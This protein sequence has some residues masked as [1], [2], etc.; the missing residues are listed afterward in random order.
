MRDIPIAVPE[1]HVRNRIDAVVPH[2]VTSATQAERFEEAAH[3]A[4]PR[5]STLHLS[6]QH[7][8]PLVR[9][10]VGLVELVSQPIF[11]L[12]PG[13]VTQCVHQEEATFATGPAGRL[14]K[15]TSGVAS[16]ATLLPHERRVS[17]GDRVGS[18]SQRAMKASDAAGA[19]RLGSEIENGRPI[20]PRHDRAS[21]V[22]GVTAREVGVRR[23]TAAR[24]REVM[25]QVNRV[26]LDGVPHDRS[27]LPFGVPQRSRVPGRRFHRTL[28][29]GPPLLGGSNEPHAL[30]AI[31]AEC[32][33]MPRCARSCLRAVP[34]AAGR[35]HQ[36][37]GAGGSR[38][39][40]STRQSMQPTATT[41]AANRIN[42]STRVKLEG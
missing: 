10:E 25:R 22:A 20:G 16:P 3:R 2:L 33:P 38:G 7:H 18:E 9:P 4:G 8:V 12:E 40:C 13:E 31:C 21:A 36:W 24:A 35:A 42:A 19:V 27:S 6:R 28:V 26:G 37:L 39:S 11:P 32:L 14:D 15:L 5:M 17:R 1:T 23:V 41:N 34:D 30:P 29:L